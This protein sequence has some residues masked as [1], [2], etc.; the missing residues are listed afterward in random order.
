[1]ENQPTTVSEKTKQAGEIR[2]RWAWVE[3]S[4]W[5]DCMWTALENGVKGGQWF[6]LIDKVYAMPTLRVG[7]TKVKR[8]AGSS[9]V[10]GQTVKMFEKEEES[11]LERLQRQLREGS[12]CPK[13]VK[14]VWISK[15]TGR[16]KR[17]LGIP[18]VEDRVVQTALKSVLEPIFERDFAET[19]YG[20]RPK[21]GCK[22]ALKQVARLLEEGYSWVVDADIRSYFDTILRRLLMERLGEKVADG[23]VLERIE[24][25]LKQ[26]IMEGMKHWKPTAGTPQGAV[27]SP[28]LANIYLN[29]LDWKMIQQGMKMVRYCDDLVILCRSR[30]HAEEALATLGQWLTEQGLSLNAEKTKIVD[31]SVAGGFDFLGYHFERGY[32]WPRRKSEQKFKDAI[33]AKTHRCHGKSLD[34]I[35]KSLNPI[36]RGW[37]GYFKHSHWNTFQT[38]DG[39]IRMRLRSLL[40]KRS[41]RSGRG[42][43]QDHQRWPNVF[44]EEAGL[45]SLFKTHASLC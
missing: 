22:D 3:P 12:Y 34:A 10:D 20:F 4:V 43:G 31:A 11:N 37:F 2:V 25:F 28:L 41:K 27:I 14:R 29:P 16:D 26:G 44:F 40:R 21:R 38:L 33:R 6:S 30:E 24:A 19:S 8:N 23:R 45:Y 5:T 15:L 1:M 36:L 9:G 39:W 32:R 17:P 42:R 13:P 7:F 35:I 18:T